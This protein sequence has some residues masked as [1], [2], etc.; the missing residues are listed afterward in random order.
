MTSHRGSILQRSLRDIPSP[1]LGCG[2]GQLPV[3]MRSGASASFLKKN[4]TFHH[5]SVEPGVGMLK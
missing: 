5:S 2:M 1:Q 4:H 3:N